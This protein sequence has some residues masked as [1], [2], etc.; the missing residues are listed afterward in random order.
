MNFI[1][2]AV[3][4]LALITSCCLSACRR[5]RQTPIQDL[6]KR[7]RERGRWWEE[8]TGREENIHGNF[9]GEENAINIHNRKPNIYYTADFE[10]ITNL[11]MVISSSFFFF[12]QI[13]KY[14]S[15]TITL[16]WFTLVWLITTPS[17]Y[18]TMVG[19]GLPWATHFNVIGLPNKASVIEGGVS[20]NTGGAEN[21]NK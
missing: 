21:T 10:S 4:G 6:Q 2:L 3:R 9:G 7:E 11:L 13:Y 5:K 8:T 14:L 1:S 15:L 12:L 20:V 18:H 17:L 16:T 19:G